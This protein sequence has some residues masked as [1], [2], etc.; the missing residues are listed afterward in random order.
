MYNASIT[1]LCINCQFL[2]ATSFVQ[3]FLADVI[4]VF[5]FYYF[6]FTYCDSLVDLE[7]IFAIRPLS[8]C[9]LDLIT[10]ELT[11]SALVRVRIALV[12]TAQ[13]YKIMSFLRIIIT[14]HQIQ[15]TQF[16]VA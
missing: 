12:T 14:Y 4:H 16:H 7:I 8:K 6:I 11:R 2:Q 10:S 13:H 3:H 5:I 9:R 15:R 1:N